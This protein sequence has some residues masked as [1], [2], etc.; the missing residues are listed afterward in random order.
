MTVFEDR[1]VM[2]GV[3]LGVATAVLVLVMLLVM[4]VV[5]RCRSKTDR[6]ESDSSQESVPASCSSQS[7]PNTRASSPNPQKKSLYTAAGTSGTLVRS[8]TMEMIPDF[9]MPVETIQTGVSPD[10][11]HEM[12]MDSMLQF[13]YNMLGHIQPDRFSLVSLDDDGYFSE[14]R[15]PG[16]LFFSVLYD[17]VV[18][19]LHV[20]TIKVTGLPGRDRKNS[21]RD[22]FVKLYLLP[23]DR[24]S[25]QTRVIKKTLSPVF[26]ETLDFR[27]PV[28]EV[29]SRTLR[30]S[31]YDVDKRR[32]RH[33]LGH[34]FLPLEEID[35][36]QNE[37][38]IRVLEE[39]TQTPAALGEVNLSLTFNA[40]A[41]KMKVVVVRLRNVLTANFVNTA[42]LYVRAQL[43]HGL[44]P[45][46]SRKS[47]PLPISSDPSF[48]ESFSFNVPC[49]QLD[50]C[51]IRISIMTS[52]GAAL[53]S[54]DKEYGRVTV[55]SYLYA[56]G[57]QNQ[58]WQDMISNS[59]V[60]V[61]RW[62]TLE[63]PPTTEIQ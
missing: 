40:T 32:V 34:V 44:T 15:F 2:L 56:R 18:Q 51:S 19:I 36:T 1:G 30:M 13:Q 47:V 57:D 52:H 46:K 28:D 22:P 43:M 6:R 60:P 49:R 23:D 38:L 33:S 24:T 4:L 11:Q 39:T 59:R 41:E 25:Q 29:N 10:S 58:H 35:L 3:V 55:G 8:V 7:A 9:N 45:H 53:S 48:N 17:A 37:M 12:E 42:C 50:A 16:K 21:V 14:T 63:L 26:N 5:Y 20:T 61:T 54:V 62:H 27:V 31:V